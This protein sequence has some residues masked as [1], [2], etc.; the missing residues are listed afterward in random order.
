MG[1]WVSGPRVHLG[2][3]SSR[4]CPLG[5]G[6]CDPGGR[7]HS[8]PGSATAVPAWPNGCRVRAGGGAAA[9][10]AGVVTSKAGRGPQA[11]PGSS[12]G[13]AAGARIS[14]PRTEPC[15]PECLS[16]EAVALWRPGRECES[17]GLGLPLALPAQCLA[18][19]SVV[20]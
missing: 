6:S 1:I 12:G 13:R 8:I 9:E 17:F 11:P 7:W 14:R 5:A 18:L 19:F 16:V 3:P 20:C 2:V 15:S 4:G 10:G